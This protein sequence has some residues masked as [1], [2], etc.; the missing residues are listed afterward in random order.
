MRDKIDLISQPVYTSSDALTL[1]IKFD[2][3]S[4]LPSVTDI[5]AQVSPPDFLL[6]YH[7]TRV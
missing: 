6:Q 1:P 5:S 2:T 4:V 7:H 3:L